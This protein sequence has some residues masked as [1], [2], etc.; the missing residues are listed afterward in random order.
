M[1]VLPPPTIHEVTAARAQL[2]NEMKSTSDEQIRQ[3]ITQ[4]RLQEY[5]KFMQGQNGLTPQQQQQ[6]LP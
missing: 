6:Q 5:S 3:M 2:P 1:P 4:K